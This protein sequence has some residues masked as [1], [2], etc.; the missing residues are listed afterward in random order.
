LLECI[1][2]LAARSITILCAHWLLPGRAVVRVMLETPFSPSTV[3]IVRLQ[4]TGRAVPSTRTAS[5]GLIHSPCWLCVF[6]LFAGQRQGQE[7]G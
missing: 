6:S 3:Y 2:M 7:E 5:C 4:A 1:F